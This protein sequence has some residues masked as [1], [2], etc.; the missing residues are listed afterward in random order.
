MN[1]HNIN[2]Y[3]NGKNKKKI[4][5]IGKLKKKHTGNQHATTNK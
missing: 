5:N 1:I 4:E 3:E 2:S